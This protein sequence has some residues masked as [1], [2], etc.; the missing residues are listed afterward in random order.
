MDR[1]AHRPLKLQFRYRLHYE[2]ETSP[3]MPNPRMNAWAIFALSSDAFPG[4]EVHLRH[5]G[6]PSG[7]DTAKRNR[8]RLTRCQTPANPPNS[9]KHMMIMWSQKL[10]LTKTTHTTKRYLSRDVQARHRHQR[11]SKPLQTIAI[12]NLLADKETSCHPSNSGLPYRPYQY[13]CSCL[14]SIKRAFRRQRLPLLGI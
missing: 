3:T 6:E 13:V 8:N 11:S 10:Q 9:T 14:S 5:G 7:H 4:G 2:I 1:S 12:R